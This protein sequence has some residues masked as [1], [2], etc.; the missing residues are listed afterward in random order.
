MPWLP[1]ES[2]DYIFDHLYD[3]PS[4]L[5]TCALV[6]KA[7]V[8]PSNGMAM[9]EYTVYQ[10]PKTPKRG[11]DCVDM[12]SW[13]QCVSGVRCIGHQTRQNCAWEGGFY[14]LKMDHVPKC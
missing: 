5:H 12:L 6:C 2:I 7:W 10:K 1:L 9:D 14:Y 8:A 13:L 11:I 4:D 3:S